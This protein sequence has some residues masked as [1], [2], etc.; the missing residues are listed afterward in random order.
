MSGDYKF[1][2][3]FEEATRELMEEC[4]RVRSFIP[5]R[6]VNT[7]LKRQ[8]WQTRWLKANEKM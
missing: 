6:L 3:G 1:I 5:A 7:N 4:A 8:G 2:E